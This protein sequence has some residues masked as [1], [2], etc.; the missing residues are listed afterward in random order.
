M[1]IITELLSSGHVNYEYMQEGNVALQTFAIVNH[2]P[3]TLNMQYNVNYTDI[4]PALVIP[5]MFSPTSWFSPFGRAVEMSKEFNEHYVEDCKG[6]FMPI[7]TRE[8][9]EEFLEK[10]K[11]PNGK[12]VVSGLLSTE[13]ATILE[14][15]LENVQKLYDM[16]VRMFGTNHFTD[17]SVCCCCCCCECCCC[18]FIV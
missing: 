7:K 11:Q 12:T 2:I 3:H 6:K 15:K 14:S 16:G 18:N 4:F 17:N 10:R 8:D 9:L 1:I 5:Q 13:G